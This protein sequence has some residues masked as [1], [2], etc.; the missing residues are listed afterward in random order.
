MC[1]RKRV[2]AAAELL[3]VVSAGWETA[4]RGQTP[5]GG[6][7]A[8]DDVGNRTRQFLMRV[9]NRVFTERPL[10][11]VEV[12]AHL[13]GHPTEYSNNS[14]WAYL[15]TSVLYWQVFRQ[16]KHLRRESGAVAT[17]DLAEESVIV[18]EEGQRISLVEAYRHGAGGFR[19]SQVVAGPC[20]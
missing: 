12:I 6:A 5:G 18:E 10:S 3:P 8:G 1:D 17:G 4:A 13:L 11:Q 7:A 19:P 15:N 2:A 16:W 14:A 9:A 20:R